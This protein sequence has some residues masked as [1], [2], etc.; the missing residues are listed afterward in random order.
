[1]S[2]LF[3]YPQN[4]DEVRKE[5]YKRDSWGCRKCGAKN[6]K[7]YAHHLI[8]LSKSG[9]NELKNLVTLCENCHK[10][11]HFHM[12]YGKI[13]SIL[14]TVS[15]LLS[16]IPRVFREAGFIVIIFIFILGFAIISISIVGVIETNRA[17]K[18]LLQKIRTNQTQQI[19]RE[20]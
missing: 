19:I 14:I 15:F 6:S 11:V 18:E 10:D 4:W 16:F 13:V 3:N 5:V 1:M 12:K 9:S 7:L 8:P 2:W 17:K 20:R